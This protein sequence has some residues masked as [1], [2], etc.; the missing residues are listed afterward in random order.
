MSDV[1][2][3]PISEDPQSGARR[4]A[5]LDGGASPLRREATKARLHPAGDP[6]T[7][8]ERFV[9]R[10]VKARTADE[11][12]VETV[13]LNKIGDF[14]ELDFGRLFTW[15]GRGRKLAFGLAMVGAVVG[16][17]YGI[18]GTPKFTVSTDVMINPNNLQVVSD[19]LFQQPSQADAA[20]L[21]AASKLRVM[22]SGN[23]LLRVV[24]TLN[25]AS[26]KEFYD[27]NPG[28]FSLSKLL[29]GGST[30]TATAATDPKT[31]AL[32]ALERDVSTK[33]DEKSFV[34]T[35]LVSSESA[36]KSIHI[37]TAVVKSFQDELAKAEADGA[38]RTAKALNDRLEALKD[39]VK[40]AEDKEEAKGG[41]V[42]FAP[43]DYHLLVEEDGCLALSSDELVNHSRPS[44]DVLFESAA[45]AFGPALAGVVLTGANDDG[46]QGLKA[47]VEAGGVGLIQD[48][49]EA[50]A[51]AMPT[52]ARAAC[53]SARVMTLEAIADYLVGLA[54][55]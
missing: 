35:L 3:R 27:P 20:L 48:T 43:S 49:D 44:I 29:G 2:D 39:S 52:A 34:A 19:D 18:V 45:D 38:S 47:I 31:A 6:A 16:G 54:P 21:A 32:G 37:S 41:V 36:E 7:I 1:T 9:L 11:A 28:G 42:Y 50:Y 8:T 53:P 22:T 13:T 33:A 24:D 15:L 51:S 55:A 4:L 14:L 12:P 17:L 40:E 26:D 23:V 30:T 5:R 46:A 10:T 25:L